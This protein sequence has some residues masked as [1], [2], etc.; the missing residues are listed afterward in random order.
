[1]LTA[2]LLLLS[3]DTVVT[4]VR[5]GWRLHASSILGRD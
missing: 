4:R 1:M 2:S 5:G 3:W